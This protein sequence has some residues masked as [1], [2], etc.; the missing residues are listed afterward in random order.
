MGDVMELQD[1][2]AG[3]TELAAPNVGCIRRLGKV[4]TA[5]P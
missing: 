2:L 4:A 1:R 3:P 5:E